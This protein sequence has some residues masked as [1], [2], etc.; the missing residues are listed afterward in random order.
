MAGKY[1]HRFINYKNS[2]NY[3]SCKN[4]YLKPHNL[5]ENNIKKNNGTPK[6]AGRYRTGEKGSF[7]LYFGKGFLI[8]LSIP[9]LIFMVF[10]FL[11]FRMNLNMLVHL[12]IML[13][14]RSGAARS[15]KT[16]SLPPGRKVR[17][18]HSPETASR[19]PRGP[20]SRTPPGSPAGRAAR[21]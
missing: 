13:P 6:T 15:H 14:V 9:V 16:V 4:A 12:Y 1:D 20:P 11:V 21:D 19:P 2:S 5:P 10:L 3:H 7:I 17:G 8:V 18:T